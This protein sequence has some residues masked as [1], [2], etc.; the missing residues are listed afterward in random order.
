MKMSAKCQPFCFSFNVS[1]KPRSPNCTIS[2]LNSW[3]QSCPW[4]VITN[5]GTNC[6]AYMWIYSWHIKGKVQ[7]IHDF[8][9]KVLDLGLY[10]PIMDSYIIRTLDMQIAESTTNQWCHEWINTHLSLSKLSLILSEALEKVER[11]DKQFIALMMFILLSSSW[12]SK[13]NSS[14][15][16]RKTLG[17]QCGWYHLINLMYNW[18]TINVI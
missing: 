18:I 13:F 15:F 12:P 16:M 17:Q 1:N 11:R 2:Y 8:I 5:S 6:L 4:V 9:V 14:A 3:Q 10:L 7:R